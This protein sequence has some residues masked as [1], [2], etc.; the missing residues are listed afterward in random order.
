MG[1][2]SSF[3][4]GEIR[5]HFSSL[6]VYMHLTDWACLMFIL[7]VSMFVFCLFRYKVVCLQLWQSSIGFVSVLCY[8]PFEIGRGSCCQIRR[9]SYSSFTFFFILSILSPYCHCCCSWFLFLLWVFNSQCFRIAFVTKSRRIRFALSI[10]AVYCMAIFD[11]VALR[12]HACAYLWFSFSSNVYIYIMWIVLAFNTLRS[13]FA[14]FV[15]LLSC[16][17]VFVCFC[18]CFWWC[19]FWHQI[20]ITSK[21]LF[22]SIFSFFSCLVWF[23]D[24]FCYFVF[25]FI[26]FSSQMPGTLYPI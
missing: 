21:V 15:I 10:Y 16:L 3:N 9:Y 12:N 19:C 26:R 22:G 13:V 23:V 1:F 14:S 6:Y 5:A 4:A 7:P 11:T 24:S 2:L 20:G 25:F 17:C 18:C 8:R